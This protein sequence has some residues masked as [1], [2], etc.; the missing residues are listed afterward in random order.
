M[1]EEIFDVDALLALPRLS[2][3][4]VS[5]D[6]AR[7]VTAVAR[8]DA[9]GTAF[10]SALWDVG[11]DG[12]AHPRRLTR[13][14]RGELGGTFLCDGSL[15]FLSARPAPDADDAAGD[16]APALWRL[17]AAGGEAELVAAPPGGVDAVVAA[18][19]TAV[20]VFAAGTHPQTSGW[21]GDA[22]KEKARCDQGVSAQLFSHYPIRYWDQ[23]LGP[24]ER[25]LYAVTLDGET[26]EPMDLTPEP[27]RS[28]DGASFDVTADGAT[29]IASRWRAVS[30]PR[31]RYSDLI[32]ISTETG[33]LHVLTSDEDAFFGA[34]ACSPDGRWVVAV[35]ESKA[36]VDTPPAISLW[37]I[38]LDGTPSRDV[39][40]ALDLWPS[41]PVWAPD[42][43]AVFFT[44]DAQGRT[45]AY[46][47]DIATGAVTRLSARGAFTD[48]CVAPDGRAL[49][50]LQSTVTS[51]PQPV[52]L[53]PVTPDQEPRML[54]AAWRGP[55]L[56]G[57]LERVVAHAEDDA[58][59]WS[60][61]LLPPDAGDTSPAP[62]AVLIH[63]G[64]LASW[65]GWHW[66]WSP[67]VLA[68]RGY[69][70]LLPDPALS[71]GYGQDFV[72]R[73]WGRWGDVVYRD[74]MAA[75]DT[76][77][78]R[79]DIDAARTAALGGSFGGYMANW[80]A[81][82]TDR[83]RAI[84]THASLWDL[85]LFHGSTDVGVWWEQELGD[86]YL[87]GTR[88]EEN[89]PHRHVDAITTPMLVIHGERDYRVPIDQAL[90]L[91]TDLRRHEVESLFLYFPDENHW[92]LKPNN[93][94]LWYATVLGWL[95]THVLGE[96]WERPELL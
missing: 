40:P 90:K 49:Y 92:I 59:I 13:S 11:V 72:V 67:H 38:A 15:L 88:Y 24:R 8:P 3:L 60:W 36:S 44:A 51:P 71:T 87:D 33:D 7:V 6:G 62:L 56:P 69:A 42:S 1:P 16:P 75:V 85:T 35:R 91:W 57:R 29:V 48:L 83:F 61:L 18:R 66:R 96:R 89:S 80:V 46:R 12:D 30:D 19:A 63:G 73:G 55:Q 32:A 10:V 27:G 5:P 94:R 86:P 9:K 25:H 52:A 17:P 64:P 41:R 14:A 34:P 39:T 70:V 20:V 93:V 65:S 22:A 78:W 4:G 26:P 28:L 95:G 43:T 50:G 47:V 82:H 74:L 79:P 68:A 77:S 2:G 76:V 37:L 84:V 58:E 21:E 53:D 81:G 45:P 54:T 23:F 31:R